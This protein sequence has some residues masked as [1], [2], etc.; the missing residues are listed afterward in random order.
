MDVLN[1]AGAGTWQL[2]IRDSVWYPD[3]LNG[4]LAD[5]VE[6]LLIDG[7]PSTE[8]MAEGA[9]QMINE[10]L[11]ALSEG[12]PLPHNFSEG[13][14]KLCVTAT[15]S[16]SQEELERL[17]RGALEKLNARNVSGTSAGWFQW[18]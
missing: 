9:M 6:A 13:R 5:G 2:R 17:V 7:V 18:N 8:G 10:T 4:K 1:A 11:K 12:R 3:Y 14:F 16:A 15:A